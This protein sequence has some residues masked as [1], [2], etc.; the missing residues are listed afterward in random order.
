VGFSRKFTSTQFSKDL[1]RK[2]QKVYLGVV[3][4]PSGEYAAPVAYG[5]EFHVKAS[6]KGQCLET[7]GTRREQILNAAM[8]HDIHNTSRQV[9]GSVSKV[10][11]G[12]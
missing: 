8:F 4:V 7:S 3:S 2:F 6:K 10:S 9:L 11:E 5:E 12:D 1:Q